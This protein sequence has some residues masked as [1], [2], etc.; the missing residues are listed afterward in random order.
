MQDAPFIRGSKATIETQLTGH[1][2]FIPS[3]SNKHPAGY[4]DGRI[5]S[6]ARFPAANAMV[7][8]AALRTSGA[9]VSH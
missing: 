7:A 9:T 4:I 8:N 6:E 5:G 1:V 2:L 3:H